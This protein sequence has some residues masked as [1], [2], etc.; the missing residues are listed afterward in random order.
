MRRPHRF[1][2][3]VER[4]DEFLRSAEMSCCRRG[5]R[6]SECAGR[7]LAC[8]CAVIA[9]DCPSGPAEIVDDGID[10][11][12]VASGDAAALAAAMARLMDGDEDRRRLGRA[13]A[14]SAGRFQ[15]A[16]IGRRWIGLLAGAS[17]ARVTPQAE[18]PRFAAER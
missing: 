3:L 13:A 12:L 8:G 17:G 14:K 6:V 5:S 7:G 9:A 15:L 4:S 2:G 16:A 1:A 11:V 10:G 18:S